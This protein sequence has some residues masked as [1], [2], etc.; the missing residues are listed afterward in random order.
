MKNY[1][2]IDSLERSGG[3]YHIPKSV[4]DVISH[5]FPGSTTI[6]S[7]KDLDRR[8]IDCIVQIGSKQVTLDYKFREKDPLHFLRGVDD[9]LLEEWSV[10]PCDDCPYGKIGWTLDLNKQADYVLWV[11]TRPDIPT[12]RR[13]YMA[14]RSILQNVFAVNLEHWKRTYEI[15]TFNE[16]DRRKGIAW[17]TRCVCVPRSVVHDEIIIRSTFTCGT[18]PS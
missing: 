1:D 5:V 11:W 8:G 7:A 10:L 3:D 17:Q 9:L 4:R 18:L 16:R 15:K 6:K 12:Y 13:W 14:P 2:F